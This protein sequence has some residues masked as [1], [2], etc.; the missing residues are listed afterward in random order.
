MSQSSILKLLK[1]SKKPMSS[2]ELAESLELSQT[3]V[4]E[5]IKRLLKHNEIKY[6]TRSVG[7]IHIRFYFA[8]EE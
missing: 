8:V 7:R 5:S 2:R 6:I 3:S 4:Y 1:R